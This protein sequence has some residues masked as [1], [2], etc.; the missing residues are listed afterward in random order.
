MPWDRPS[1]TRRKKDAHAAQRVGERLMTLSE[2]Q[3]LRMGLP[4]DL[5]EAVRFA[6][7]VRSRGALR[8][9]MQFIGT[10]MRREDPE[11]IRT[12]IEKVLVPDTENRRFLRF[13]EN[14]R[15]RLV[16]G[17]PDQLERLLRRIPEEKDR[18]RLQTL[19]RS[20]RETADES[21]SKASRLLFRHLRTLADSLPS[22]DDSVPVPPL[23]EEMNA[24]H[25]DSEETG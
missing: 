1:K 12:Q 8:R 18:D 9:Q 15:E 5:V 16:H 21:S 3:L 6:R 25:D 20:A 10:L 19:V 7:N 22:V 17:D 11:R 13:V 14:W 24:D 4:E 23:Q 2:D